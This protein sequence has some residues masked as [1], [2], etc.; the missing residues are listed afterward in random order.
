MV[1]GWETVML[2]SVRRDAQQSGERKRGEVKK[3]ENASF[4]KYRE[5]EGYQ[6]RTQQ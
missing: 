1:G 6:A 5:G 3:V 4:W 2:H